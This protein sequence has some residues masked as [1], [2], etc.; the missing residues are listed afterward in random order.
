[1][2]KRPI[3]DAHHHLWDPGAMP[4]PW[5]SGPPFASSVA[6]DVA[7]IAGRYL[8]EHYLADAAGYDVVKTVHVDGG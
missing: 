7:P 2:A 3:V 4:Y 6:G 1:M 8:V 5:L